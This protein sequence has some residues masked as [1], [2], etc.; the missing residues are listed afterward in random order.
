MVT[1]PYIRHAKE[2]KVRYPVS[3]TYIEDSRKTN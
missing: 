1:R 2:P 3:G